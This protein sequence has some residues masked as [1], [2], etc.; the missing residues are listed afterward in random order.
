MTKKDKFAVC[1]TEGMAVQPVGGGCAR[2]ARACVRGRTTGREG[3]SVTFHRPVVC[4]IIVVLSTANRICKE[5]KKHWSANLPVVSKLLE[6]NRSVFAVNIRPP[7]KFLRF[8]GKIM[9]I[10]RAEVEQTRTSLRLEP[11]MIIIFINIVNMFTTDAR[12]RATISIILA[13]GRMRVDL[14][15]YHT[16]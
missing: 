10:A 7:S 8:V 12:T 6:L 9:A 2:D 13:R 4:D 5:I 15:I 11:L 1:V 16:E 14:K 3:G